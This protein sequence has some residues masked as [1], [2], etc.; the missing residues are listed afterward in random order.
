[1]NSESD[2]LEEADKMIQFQGEVKTNQDLSDSERPPL[3]PLLAG[4]GRYIGSRASQPLET[5]LEQIKQTLQSLPPPASSPASILTTWKFLK[6]FH[7]ADIHKIVNMIDQLSPQALL[8]KV[9][10]IEQ[11]THR[12]DVDQSHQFQLAEEMHLLRK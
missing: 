3:P 2:W 12:L 8:G 10:E 11:L 4:S 1:M 9:R 5:I 6:S 7:S